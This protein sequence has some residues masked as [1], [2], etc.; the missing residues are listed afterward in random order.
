[1]PLARAQGLPVVY[2]MQWYQRYP[3]GVVSFAEK[4]IR[5][6]EDLRGRKIGIP[7]LFGAS[8]I[9]LKAI[10]REG[11]LKESDVT[12][13]SIGF[14]Q[15]EALIDGLEDAAVIYVA[16]EPVKLMK[17]G[18]LVNVI[19]ASENVLVGNGLVTNQ[20]TIEETGAYDAVDSYVTGIK[21]PF[22][23][24]M[25]DLQPRTIAINYSK[26]SEI[27]DGLTY[28]MYLVLYDLL[29]AIGY[30][31]RLI[32]AEKITSALR[33]RKSPSELEAIKAAISETEK[34]FQLVKEF[35][36]PGKTEKQIAEF[37]L[38]EV[39]RLQLQTAWGGEHL[40]SCFYR[41]RNCSGSLFS[42]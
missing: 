1:V 25:K 11:G 34:I 15:V 22:E 39:K 42:D 37:M 27:S 20:K 6:P 17:E 24:Y 31:D 40:S 13:D 33:E 4:N 18:Y 2:V 19:P 8:Y 35:I 26:T 10:L 21:E 14:T 38:G 36:A 9:G 29:Q 30:E 3:V 41:A 28:G 16:N 32:S 7:G 5:K 23:R 12:L